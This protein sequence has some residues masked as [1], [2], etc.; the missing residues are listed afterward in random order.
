MSRALADLARVQG[1]KVQTS[2]L[3]PG[4]LRIRSAAWVI[5]E[6]LLV[7]SLAKARRRSD[8]CVNYAILTYVGYI[9]LCMA[10]VALKD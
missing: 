10:S 6:D 9:R 3:V 4:L 5:L 7:V 1:F 8:R 2:Q